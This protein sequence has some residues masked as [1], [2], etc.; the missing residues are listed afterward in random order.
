MGIY[1][2]ETLR[3]WYSGSQACEQLFRLLR[4]M[5]P[6]FSTIVNFS[7]NGAINRIHKLQFLATAE[8]DEEIIFP[9]VKRRLLETQNEGNESLLVPDVK[10]ILETIVNSKEHAIQ[11]TTSCEMVLDSFDDKDLL[12]NLEEVISHAVEHDDEE[13]EYLT[14]SDQSSMENSSL[15]HTESLSSADIVTIK[16]DLTQIK[17][18]K[19]VSSINSLPMYEKLKESGSDTE[20]RRKYSLCDSKV[21]HNKFVLYEGTYIRKTTALYILQEK[22]Q[23]SADRLLRVRALQPTHI[24]SNKMPSMVPRKS[25]CSGDL[26]IFERVDSPMC[27]LG[28]IIQ[29]SYLDGSKRDRQYSGNFVDLSKESVKRIG[30]YANW[31]SA[32]SLQSDKEEAFVSFRAINAKFTCGYVSS[33][34]YITTIDDHMIIDSPTHSFAIPVHILDSL[35]PNWRKRLSFDL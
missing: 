15:S 32:L 27:L 30:V 13:C 19:T 33:K 28:R 24:Y 10:E 8:N 29:F 18:Q 1:P 23:L 3:V 21:Q 34:N 12:I 17:L 5:T 2:S 7:L 35:L 16:E 4:S 6:T 9:R 31:Y 25:I 14:D 11:I 22:S 20:A 26:C